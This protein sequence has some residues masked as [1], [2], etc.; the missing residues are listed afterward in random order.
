M[1]KS[2]KYIYKER[3]IGPHI[4]VQSGLAFFVIVMGALFYLDAAPGTQSTMSILTM[5][6]G[7][8]WLVLHH[9]IENWLHGHGHD[10]IHH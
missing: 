8:L 9:G 5:V 6:F 7:V 1:D 3:K 2:S 10:H 4:S